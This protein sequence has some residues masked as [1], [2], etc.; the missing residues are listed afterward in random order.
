VLFVSIVG[1]FDE[2]AVKLLLAN[3]GLVSGD[4]QNCISSWIEGKCHALNSAVGPE[5]QFF[6]IGVTR[7][8]QRVDVRPPQGRS[9]FAKWLKGGE[10]LVLHRFGELVELGLEL[11]VK[12]SYPSNTAL[13]H[14]AHYA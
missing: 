2:P 1:L 3:S 4:E 7:I 14:K 8:V 5:A 9:E 12:R 11:R 10:Q 6:H 13:C